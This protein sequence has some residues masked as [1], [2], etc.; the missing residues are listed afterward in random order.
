M[1][2][3]PPPPDTV[4][5][6]LSPLKYVEELAVPVAE[7]I[8]MSTASVAIVVAFPLL[9]TSP[10]RLALVVT[11]PAVRPDA[12]PVQF[13]S[14][15]LAG[16]PRAGVTSVGLVAKTNA[17]LP[18]SSEITPANCAEVVAAMTERLFVV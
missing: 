7:S 15:P 3:P 10:V 13:V 2:S 14:T 18:V 17:P 12:V 4:A 8:A 11:V 6:V 5:H 1:T 9:V 16:V